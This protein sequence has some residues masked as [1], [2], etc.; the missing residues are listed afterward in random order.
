MTQLTTRTR[1]LN[2]RLSS[3]QLVVILSVLALVDQR[4]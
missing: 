4:L 3:N 2:T 1:T